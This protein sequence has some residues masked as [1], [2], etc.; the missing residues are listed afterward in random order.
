MRILRQLPP[1]TNDTFHTSRPAPDTITI[2]DLETVNFVIDFAIKKGRVNVKSSIS[3]PSTPPD[4]NRQTIEGDCRKELKRA[5][6][7]RAE[8]GKMKERKKARRTRQKQ[9]TAANRAQH[10]R[11]L[12]KKKIESQLEPY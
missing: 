1:Q 7:F 5:K 6:R 8:L 3:K 12:A 4:H 11:D 2:D 9:V 10:Y